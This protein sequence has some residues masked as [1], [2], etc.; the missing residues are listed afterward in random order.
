[1]RKC[2]C[3]CVWFFFFACCHLTVRFTL[4]LPPSSRH[5][6]RAQTHISNFINL[7]RKGLLMGFAST[8][9]ISVL[10][11]DPCMLDDGLDPPPHTHT[12]PHTP[13]YGHKPHYHQPNWVPWE[14]EQEQSPS[15]FSGQDTESSFCRFIMG[16][17]RRSSQ[18]VKN[19]CETDEAFF[20]LLQ[21]SH[22]LRRVWFDTGVW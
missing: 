4:I 18:C 14:Q 11:M 20:F 17:H 22:R 13:P 19:L 9:Q 12:P 6:S 15:L 10:L 21:F 16:S 7:L 5:S 2:V 3:V 1:M 8:A